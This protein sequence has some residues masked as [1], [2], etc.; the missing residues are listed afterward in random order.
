MKIYW[1]TEIHTDTLY[2]SSRFEVSNAL[3]KR[4]HKVTLILQRTINEKHLSNEEYIALPTIDYRMIYKLI[5]GFF[6]FFYL[7]FIIKKGK[8]DVIIIDGVDIWTAFIIPLKFLRIPLLLDIRSL[9]QNTKMSSESI[10][11][12]TS[13]SLSKYLVKGVT[14]ITPELKHV[15][16]NTYGMKQDKIGIWTSGVSLENFTNQSNVNDAI[17]KKGPSKPF[18]IMYHG[19][20]SQYRGIENIIQSLKNLDDEIRKNIQLLLVGFNMKEIDKLLLFCNQL[21]V[22]DLVRFVPQVPYEKIPSYISV[23]DVGIIPLPP[24]NEWC[25]ESSPLKTLEYLAM[26]KPIIA[27]KIPFHQRIF[28]KGRCGILIENSEPES[29]AAAITYL[30]KHKEELDSMGRTGREIVEKYY[31]WD[32]KALDLE[33]FINTIV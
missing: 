8:A 33:K 6:L 32:K 10:F 20:Y 14:T 28:E 30:Y 19:S 16:V 29:I 4:G 9:K 23:C 5:F 15:L 22:S 27:T 1:I 11:F 31:T 13:L 21:G 12:S 3:K 7:P 24:E 18:T 17:I 2:K 25:R 26:C